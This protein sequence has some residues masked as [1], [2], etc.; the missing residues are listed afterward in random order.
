[1][2][3]SELRKPYSCCYERLKQENLDTFRHRIFYMNRKINH[4]YNNY[5]YTLIEC[6]RYVNLLRSKSEIT[7]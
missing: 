5:I 6:N 2:D 1:M 7:D 4:T 3:E